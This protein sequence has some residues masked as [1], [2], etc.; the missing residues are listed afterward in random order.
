MNTIMF[1]MVAAGVGL[2][3]GLVSGLCII[4]DQVFHM[5]TAL[6]NNQA[7]I[8]NFLDDID[9]RTIDLIKKEH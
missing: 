2:M 4:R 7:E 8:I 1:F 5:L 9:S 6:Y 3:I